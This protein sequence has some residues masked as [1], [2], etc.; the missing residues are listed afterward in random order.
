VFVS[1][2]GEIGQW[3]Q[4]LIPVPDRIINGVAGAIG[5]SIPFAIGAKVASPDRT[6]LAVLGD[7][8]FGFHMA[9]FETAVRHQVPFITVIGNDGFWNAERQLQRRKYGEARAVGCSLEQGIRYDQL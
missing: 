2:G 5:P 4:A 7:G 9:E 6:V 3:A 1:D 8:T